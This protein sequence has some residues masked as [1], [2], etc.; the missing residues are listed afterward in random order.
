[1]KILDVG[2]GKHKILGVKGVDIDPDSNADII[3][4]LNDFP[5]PFEDNTFDKVYAR[6]ILEHLDKAELVMKE[7]YRICKSNAKII[8][9]VPHF[10]N[11]VNTW[12]TLGHRHG[13]SCTWFTKSLI[14]TSCFDV[15]K[16]RLHYL[17]KHYFT[18]KNDPPRKKNIAEILLDKTLTFLANRNLHL[19]ERGW[20][21]L[22]GGFSMIYVEVIVK[23]IKNPNW[24]F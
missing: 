20:C 7:L 5:Y 6:A 16:I 11:G 12:G 3:H 15:K 9:T 13:F 18:F 1:M 23:K 8:I 2:C 21:Y 19:C 10:S 17:A 4:D 24:R 14:Q 22:V